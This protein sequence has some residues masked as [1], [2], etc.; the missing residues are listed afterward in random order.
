ML[1]TGK[2]ILDTG[3]LILDT[4]KL[5]PKLISKFV[6]LIK[7]QLK[8]LLN[9]YTENKIF[10]IEKT[11]MDDCFFNLSNSPVKGHIRTNLKLG[12]KLSPKTKCDFFKQIRLLNAETA[13]SI[14]ADILNAFKFKC[15]IV[16]DNIIGSL[17]SLTF[18]TSKPSF[19][20]QIANFTDSYSTQLA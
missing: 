2:L 6:S 1:D 4:G 17:D 8:K 14:Q 15:H 16:Q 7:L 9:Q 10:Q 3:K 11:L 18:K 19:I 13:K 5:I 12:K 20:S